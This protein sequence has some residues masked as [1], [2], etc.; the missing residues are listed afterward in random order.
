MRGLAQGNLNLLFPLYPDQPPFVQ[1]LK[2]YQCACVGAVLGGAP[3]GAAG[4]TFQ[5]TNRGTG[6]A[7]PLKPP[8]QMGEVV[9]FGQ[10]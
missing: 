7:S 8:P 3:G 1:H 9:P 5:G 4:Q 2:A 10:Q 6:G